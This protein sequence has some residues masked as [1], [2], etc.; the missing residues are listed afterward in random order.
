MKEYVEYDGVV[1]NDEDTV[2]HKFKVG[3]FKRVPADDAELP[4][5]VAEIVCWSDI[6]DA[7]G[8]VVASKG[9]KGDYK[10]WVEGECRDEFDV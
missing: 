3:V 4:P 10:V 6:N 2:V 8:H 5:E 1:T 9:S 7:I